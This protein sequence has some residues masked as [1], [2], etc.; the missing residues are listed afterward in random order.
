[1]RCRALFSD[2]RVASNLEVKEQTVSLRWAA[3][4]YKAACYLQSIGDDDGAERM[5][6]FSTK[7]RQ[8]ALGRD[9]DD[10]LSSV[11]TVAMSLKN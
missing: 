10:T 8:K 5:A 7:T 6:R 11:E 1:M 4:V 2:V 9:H 3:L